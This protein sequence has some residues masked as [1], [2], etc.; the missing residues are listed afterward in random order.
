MVCKALDRLFVVPPKFLAFRRMNN[1]EA[2]I[3]SLNTVY[4][5]TRDIDIGFTLSQDGY[6]SCIA[7]LPTQSEPTAN[8]FSKKVPVKATAKSYFTI[9]SLEPSTEYNVYCFA[10]NMYEA[11]STTSIAN[12]KRTTTTFAENDG[13]IVIVG[14]G[15]AEK[16]EATITILGSKAGEAWC[17][18]RNG[19]AVPSRLEIKESSTSIPMMAL[20]EAMYTVTNLEAGTTYQM[21]CTTE[22]A[23][24]KAP[25]VSDVGRVMKEVT[26]TEPWYMTGLRIV[27]TLICLCLS[28]MFSGMNLGVMGLDLIQVRTIAETDIDAVAG[29][30][31][32]EEERKS[33][34]RDKEHAAKI[35]PLRK[36][37]NHLLVTLLIG[38]VMVN[39]LISII[40][41]DLTSG[42][43]GFILS[44]IFIT[45]FG[46]VLPQAYGSRH[47]LQLGAMCA[48]L[49]RI[50]L[51][52]LWIICKPVAMALDYFLGE[53]MGNIYNR[54]QLYTMFELY[55]NLPND[56]KK[57]TIGTMQGA[58][59]MDT[60]AVKD[61]YHKLDNVF[62]LSDTTLL[63][64]TTCMEIFKKGYSRIPIY[65]EDRQNIVGVLHVKELIMIDPNQSIS[66]DSLLKL[67]PSSVL[68]VDHM[69]TVAECI[70][71]MV[72][73]HTELAFVSKT[74]Q[75]NTTDNSIE[76]IGIATMEDMVR[77]VMRLEMVDET[78]MLENA[79]TE[80][81]DN[82]FNK[83]MVSHMD[84][85]TVDIISHF[86]NQSLS[87]Q[88]LFLPSDILASLIRAGSIV[89]VSVNSQPLYEID[90]PCDYATVILQGVFTVVVGKD[91]M[92]TEKPVF[93]VINLFAI[94]DDDYV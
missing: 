92:V 85:T 45:T 31:L 3:F 78:P 68:V 40:T 16:Y 79:E 13:A 20:S 10:E 83:M 51:F 23:D 84:P 64:H 19:G 65:H 71:D 37:G 6:V 12:S 15:G 82:M 14:N 94:L 1:A 86:I 57:D 90:K 75:S 63:D 29:E 42:T 53:E 50:V 44:T 9:D 32:N 4:P 11:A 87:K 43:V 76:L 18:A 21:Y 46:E 5:G 30:G 28:G 26:T 41:A 7:R 80:A 89:P 67:F 93:S 60:K 58:L 77:A 62:M 59:V 55:R 81:M 2:P 56:L 54:Y 35:L 69:R 73:A 61:Y 74:V 34:M 8:D 25:M 72:N 39:S 48:T 70:K 66:V 17:I 27:A 33:I 24:L 91:R 47:G 88:G 22:S 36:L 52:V 49:T 38:N